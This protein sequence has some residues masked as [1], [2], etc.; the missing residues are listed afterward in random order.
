MV[1][2]KA[3]DIL[4]IAT[5]DQREL[6]LEGGRNDESIDCVSG[7]HP[8]GGEQGASALGDTSGQFDDSHDIATQELVDGG[9][10]TAP[11]TDLSK[12]RRRDSDKGATFLGDP[13][14][15]TRPQS[16]GAAPCWVR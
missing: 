15:S 8:G 4:E 10:Q 5:C 3:F 14:D 16:K 12:D 9:I 6:K 7:R 2:G 1:G 13:G 11:T